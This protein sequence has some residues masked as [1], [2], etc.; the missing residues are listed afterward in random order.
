[1]EYIGTIW[2]GKLNKKTY[3]NLKNNLLK[4]KKLFALYQ[5]LI[6]YF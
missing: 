3:P 4:E 6:N 2:N 1:M 5:D